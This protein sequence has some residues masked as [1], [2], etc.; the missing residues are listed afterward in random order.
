M[1]SCLP[2]GS[3]PFLRIDK[4]GDASVEVVVVPKASRTHLTGIHGEPGRESLRV[5]LK[6]LPE[7]GKANDALIKWLADRL[8][9]P[10]QAITLVRGETS[11]H[12]QLHLSAAAAS[13]ARWDKLMAPIIR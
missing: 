3:L 13:V 6:A 8:D 11:R 10:P 4:H 7:G 9:I 5:R 1:S 12:K 2:P